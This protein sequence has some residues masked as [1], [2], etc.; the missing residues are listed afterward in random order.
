MQVMT[1]TRR[2]LGS[3]TYRKHVY[4]TREPSRLIIL[5]TRSKFDFLVEYI[6]NTVGGISQIRFTNTKVEADAKTMWNSQCYHMK[7]LK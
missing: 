2:L 3:Q 6:T 1:M 5:I 4:G 7:R